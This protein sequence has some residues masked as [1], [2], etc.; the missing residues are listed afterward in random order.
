MALLH[1]L[2][3]IRVTTEDTTFTLVIGTVTQLLPAAGDFENHD[4]TA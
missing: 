1:S 4:T 2:R 3:P